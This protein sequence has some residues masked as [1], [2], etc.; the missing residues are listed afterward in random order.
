MD[1]VIC[2]DKNYVM[3]CGVM[4]YSICCNNQ[5]AKI[6]FHIIV[7]ESV[8]DTAKL[9]LE[10]IIFP[11]ESK[12]ALFYFINGDKCRHLPRLDKTNPKKYITKAAY[13][14]LYL[15][16]ILPKE[17][18]K[19]LYL[20]SDIIVRHSLAGLWNTDLSDYAVGVI[21]DVGEGVIDKY[22]R[23][24]Y[25]PNKGYFN[26]G[27]LL[28]NLK[29]WRDEDIT[30]EF[31]RFMQDHPDWIRLHDQ[32]V[33]NRIF[34]DRKLILPI[35]YNFQEGFLWNDLFYDYWKYEKQVLAARKDP[36]ILHFTDSKPWFKEC[37]HPYKEEFFKYQRQ[38]EWAGSPLLSNST[39]PSL[40]KKA[41]NYLK[42]LLR[43][44]KLLPQLPIYSSKYINI[45]NNDK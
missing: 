34:Y 27:V 28:I 4:L 41:M 7:D 24:R 9:S 44:M 42:D 5:D 31:A 33:M 20:D 25:P 11:Y 12:K 13:Y 39:L 30:I 8:S 2:I 37:N 45:D 23:L 22:N 38:T 1:I 6:T 36:I 19:I 26:S 29:K 43:H 21:P 17:L 40:R 15:S 14:R 16:E 3:P 10:N 32:D 18:D 35:T